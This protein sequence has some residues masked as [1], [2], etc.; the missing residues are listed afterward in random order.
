MP[1]NCA[2]F[3]VDLRLDYYSSDE[4]HGILNRSASILG[5]EITK[6][7]AKELAGRARGTPRI[8]NRLLKRVRD[9]A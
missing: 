7:G 3:G 4:I 6:D 9:Y 1:I 8:A 5:V 2:R